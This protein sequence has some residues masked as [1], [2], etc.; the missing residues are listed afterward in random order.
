MGSEGFPEA[1]EYELLGSGRSHVGICLRGFLLRP[2][3][4]DLR[5]ALYL[6]EMGLCGK[7]VRDL[8]ELV[9][10]QRL[11]SSDAENSRDGG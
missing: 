6:F 8:S 11:I 5:T 10:R 3:R 1:R 7:T 4:F 9:N 2:V